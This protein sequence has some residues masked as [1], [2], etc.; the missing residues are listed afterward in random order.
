MNGRTFVL[1]HKV[2]LVSTSLSSNLGNFF[3]K[4]VFKW[5]FLKMLLFSCSVL[6]VVFVFV[7][8]CFS[9]SVSLSYLL[10]PSSGGIENLIPYTCIGKLISCCS[11]TCARWLCHHKIM[12]ILPKCFIYIAYDWTLKSLGFLM[13]AVLSYNSCLATGAY[14]NYKITV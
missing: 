9:S 11:V 8:H 12:T 6:L 3:L 5:E 14:F 2:V 10:L 1:F 7:S 13:G 4:F